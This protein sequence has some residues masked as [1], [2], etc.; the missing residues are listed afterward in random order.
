LQFTNRYKIQNAPQYYFE[1][2]NTTTKSSNHLM[3][4]VLFHQG[5]T[6]NC[7][8]PSVNPI[9]TISSYY[10]AYSKLGTQYN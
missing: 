5:I 8:R 9:M 4:V 3:D 10:S 2:T 6:E 7:T 1:A